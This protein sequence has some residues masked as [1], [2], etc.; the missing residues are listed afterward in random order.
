[1]TRRVRSLKRLRPSTAPGRQLL[2]FSKHEIC[3]STQELRGREGI[4]MTKDFDAQAV[5]EKHGALLPKAAAIVAAHNVV[6]RLFDERFCAESN[7]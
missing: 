5:R 6:I 7:S 3:Q 1:M 4:E 2:T